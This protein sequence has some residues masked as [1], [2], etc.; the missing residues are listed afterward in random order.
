MSDLDKTKENEVVVLEQANKGKMFKIIAGVIIFLTI[1]ILGAIKVQNPDF[2]LKYIILIGIIVLFI[3]LIA[4]FGFDI[5]R[6][7]D[8]YKDV[9]KKEDKLPPIATPEQLMKRI[10]GI[11][12]NEIYQNHVKEWKNIKQQIVGS[13]LIYDFEIVPLYTEYTNKDIFHIIINAHFIDRIPT[14]LIN[15]TPNGREIFRAINMA[16]LNPTPGVDIEKTEIFNPMTNT[17]VK[18]EKKTHKDKH[19]DKEKKEDLA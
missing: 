1:I 19:K 9:S 10:E 7:F 16:S 8:N 17:I 2:P 15:P 13:N 14:I 18:T 3:G 5:Y 12:M 11:L 4:Y 6:K